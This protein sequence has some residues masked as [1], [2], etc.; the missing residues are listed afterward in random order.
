MHICQDQMLL[1]TYDYNI[2]NYVMVSNSLKF[3]FN[4]VYYLMLISEGF[5]LS[6][7]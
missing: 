5:S 6:C 3:I 7:L 1:E 2:I 4:E